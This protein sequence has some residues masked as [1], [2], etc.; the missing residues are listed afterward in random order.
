MYNETASDFLTEMEERIPKLELYKSS[1]MENY[2][3]LVH[4]IKSDS[5]YLGFTTLAKLAYQHEIKS[6]E[7]NVS[8]IMDHYLELLT[9]I[10]HIIE[11]LQQYLEVNK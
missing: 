11:L 3:I 4:S 8:Y 10:N 9:E 7:Q 6:K 1:D 2:S 5:K